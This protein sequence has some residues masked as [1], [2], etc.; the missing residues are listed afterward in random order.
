MVISQPC[1]SA[2]ET[3]DLYAKATAELISVSRWEHLNAWLC[4]GCGDWG[5]YSGWTV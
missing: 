1:S 4:V 2:L 5:R 3:A